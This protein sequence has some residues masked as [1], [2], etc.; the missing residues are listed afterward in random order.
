[1]AV[2]KFK[3]IAILVMCNNKMAASTN[4]YKVL[5]LTEIYNVAL[6][7]GMCVYYVDVL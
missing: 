5:W 7:S 2:G 3:L 4:L 6:K 1:M